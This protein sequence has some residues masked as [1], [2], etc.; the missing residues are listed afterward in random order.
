MLLKMN[1][2]KALV[3]ALFASMFLLAGLLTLSMHVVPFAFVILL[4]LTLQLSIRQLPMVILAA[5]ALFVLIVSLS[6]IDHFTS[7]IIITEN[8]TNASLLAWLYGFDQMLS[9]FAL[10][11]IFGMGLGSTGYFAFESDYAEMSSKSGLGITNLTDAYSALF[12]IGIELGLPFL[13]LLVFYLCT[14]FSAFRQYVNSSKNH[15]SKNTLAVV[16]LF[17]FS[18]TM[19]I[20]ILVKEPTYSRS[21]VYI[22]WFFLVTCLPPSTHQ[23]RDL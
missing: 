17:I 12:R 21:F 4:I 10:S 16:F 13:S 3:T 11:P 23:P 19:T 1:Y 5:S 22:A 7:R 14:R 18:L 9:A 8:I 15:N 6:E 2:R 20:G